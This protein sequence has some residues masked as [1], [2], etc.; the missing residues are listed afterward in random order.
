M[1]KV[2][3]VDVLDATVKDK[4]RNKILKFF[5]PDLRISSDF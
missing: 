3:K 1:E 2:L 4:F 5:N